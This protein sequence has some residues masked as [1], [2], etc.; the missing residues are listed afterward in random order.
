MYGQR[1]R[2]RILNEITLLKK[3]SHPSLIAFY[4]AW[5]NRESEKVVFITGAWVGWLGCGGS[6]QP[7]FRCTPLIS[8]R[9]SFTPTPAP[10][11]PHA[12]LM[13]SGTMKE[14]CSKYPISLKQIKK[15]CRDILECISYLHTPIPA[16]GAGEGG[17]KGGATTGKPA[18]IHRDIKCDNIFIQGKSIKIGD[19]GLATTDGRSVLGTP[20][21]MAPEM[22]RGWRWCN[23]D[24]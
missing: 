2:K 9:R 14:F 22:V 12:E 20:E 18:V 23:V 1:E 3:L 7:P 17:D 24:W 8:C 19:L 4:G 21:F 11:P 13:S 16:G 10:P 6:P 15:Y 5:V